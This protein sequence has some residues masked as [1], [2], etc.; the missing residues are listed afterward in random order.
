MLGSDRD[1]RRP[2]AEAPVGVMAYLRFSTRLE[3]AR[4]ERTALGRALIHAEITA[5]QRALQLWVQDRLLAVLEEAIAQG[6]LRELAPIW[7]PTMEKRSALV[8]DLEELA[9]EL[10]EI[11]PGV[12]AAVTAGIR[13]LRHDALDP[14]RLV[15]W[16]Y[17]FEG[18]TLGAQVLADRLSQRDGRG[19]SYFRVYGSATRMRWEAFG[20]RVER[21]VPPAAAE[22]ARAGAVQA[23]AVVREAFEAIH[24]ATAGDEA[25]A[26]PAS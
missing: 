22:R 20:E 1:E 13:A 4:T 26:S 6:A 17:V 14:A 12:S 3:H 11:P 7:E 21:W 24:A 2:R 19:L 5:R 18:S 15:G 10:R 16:I 23:F 9:D 25:T 8:R